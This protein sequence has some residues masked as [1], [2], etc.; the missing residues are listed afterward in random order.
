MTAAPGTAVERATCPLDCPDACGVLV[1]TDATGAFAG[2]RGDPAHPWS[3]GTLCGKTALYGEVV[4][5]PNRLL[6]PLVRRAGELR[7]A[8]WDEALDLIAAKVAPLAGA[9]VL[10]LSYGGSMGLV[11]RKFPN[12]VMNALGATH[13]DGGICDATADAGYQSV[14]G[15]CLGPDL[16]D[17]E[18]CDLL[19][20]WG[21]DMARTV[22][23]LQPRAKPRRK[24]ALSGIV[25]AGSWH[26][27]KTARKRPASRTR[28]R[29]TWLTSTVGAPAGR[30][31]GRCT[32]SSWRPK[33]A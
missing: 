31:S 29:P 14:L 23:H 5:A 9:D 25:T 22:Q 7:R 12:R 26:H 33:W 3:R 13:H 20:L 32:T 1:E 2:L 8:S 10:A 19:V 15:R 17:V 18:T 24:R 11:Q 6:H 21:C 27:T 28:P 4:R 30:R 16:D